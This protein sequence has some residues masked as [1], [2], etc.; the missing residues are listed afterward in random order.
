[1][2][3]SWWSRWTGRVGTSGGVHPDEMPRAAAGAIPLPPPR[4]R[5]GGVHFRDDDAFRAS[6]AREAERLLAEVSST[7]GQRRDG[8]GP[9][10]LEVGCGAGRLAIGLLAVDA[11]V[12]SYVGVDVMPAPIEWATAEITRRAPTYV[13]ATIDVY[14]ERYNPAG[15]RTATQATLPFEDGAFDAIYTYSVF[16]HMTTEDVLAYLGEFR[17]LLAPDGVAVSTAFVEDDVP[18]E[19]VNPPGYGPIE[20]SGA[21]HCVRFATP[22]FTRL[23]DE[24]GLRILRS[25]HGGETD[26]QSRFVFEAR[27]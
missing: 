8:R 9:A 15:H 22:F 25:E 12:S 7:V 20:W 16:S 2:G 5:A 14:N 17:R 1:M 18:D 23:V 6:A 19:S 10:I 26:G 11:R 4:L 24:A 21:L 27:D 3:R 13:F